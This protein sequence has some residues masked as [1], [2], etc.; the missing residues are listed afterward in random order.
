MRRAFVALSAIT[1]ILLLAGCEAQASA[2]LG[3]PTTTESSS[4]AETA[5]PL[6]PDPSAGDTSGTGAPS[7]KQGRVVRV[8][9]GDTAHIL[10]GGVREKVRFIGVDTPESTKEI[11]PFGQQSSAYTK[12]ALDGRTVWLETDAELRDRYGRLLAYVWLEKPTSGSDSEIRTKMF[13]AR[14]LLDGYAQVYTFPPNVRYVESFL[15]YQR[16]ARGADRGLWKVPGA[17]DP[18]E[19]HRAPVMPGAAG[20]S[21]PGLSS[22]QN[23]NDA[24]LYRTRTGARYHRDGCRSLARSRIPTTL[25][26]AES[27][28][29]TPCGVC[30]PP[31]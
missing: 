22:P 26:E 18:L 1:L 10:V 23:A 19:G 17:A 4:A 5:S 3:A 28:G 7:T 14:L 15:R 9:D 16:E 11:E 12:K 13:N 31:G 24:T 2:P 25:E 8:V 29:L 30:R 21:E 20:A 27:L 6:A